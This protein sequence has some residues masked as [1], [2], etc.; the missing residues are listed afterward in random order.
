L[1]CFS[2]PSKSKKVTSEDDVSDDENDDDEVNE[3][4]GG[5]LPSQNRSAN[6][7]STPKQKKSTKFKVKINKI[8]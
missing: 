7:K 6:S 5:I 2:K 3:E 4:Y 1:P 8:I